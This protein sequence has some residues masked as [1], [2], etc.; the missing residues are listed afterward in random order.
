MSDRSI[1]TN[2]DIHD[3]NELE[4]FRMFEIDHDKTT[5]KAGLLKKMLA[6]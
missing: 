6:I 4:M 5:E 1:L 3:T 2:T